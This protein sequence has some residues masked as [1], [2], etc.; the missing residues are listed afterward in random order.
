MGAARK[1]DLDYRLEAYFATL[2]PA[3]LREVL[4]RAER[5]QIY[6]AVTSSAV[7]MLTGA[8]AAVIGNTIPEITEDPIAS[9]RLAKQ[10]L[11]SSTN[12]PSI[13]AIRLAMA[14]EDSADKSRPGA[15]VVMSQSQVPS[16]SRN[17]VVPLYGSV[18]IIQPGGWVSIYGSHLASG[19]AVWKATF[20]RP[21]AAPAWRSMANPRISPLLVPGRLTCRRRT[22]LPQE[23]YP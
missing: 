11:A 22:T 16:I 9:V 23:W 10:L 5:W 19:T 18:N 15:G 8:S 3:S 4:K 17:G 14:G 12:T 1:L 21:W 20:P 7:A 13:K 6:A 2:R